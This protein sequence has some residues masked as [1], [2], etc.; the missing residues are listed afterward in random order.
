MRNE[1]YLLLDQIFPF[2]VFSYGILMVFVLENKSLDSL[3]RQRLPELGATLR[4]H[5]P[6]AYV[7]FFVGGLW[8]VQNLLFS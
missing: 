3:A 1:T 2:I 5:R 6:L 8:S 4:S 7:C